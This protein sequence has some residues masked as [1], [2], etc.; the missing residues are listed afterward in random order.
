V[1]APIDR[2]STPEFDV[3]DPSLGPRL[4]LEEEV[5]RATRTVKPIKRR[6]MGAASCG[7]A[8]RVLL[9]NGL[10]VLVPSSADEARPSMS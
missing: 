3:G 8:M 7:M 5:W 6:G 9:K 1:A 10:I 4:G 2:S